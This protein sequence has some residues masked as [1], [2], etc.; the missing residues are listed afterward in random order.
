MPEI[1]GFKA[2]WKRM[3]QVFEK[4]ATAAVLYEPVEVGGELLLQATVNGFDGDVSYQWEFSPDGEEFNDI[5]GATGDTYSKAAQ[6]S[7]AGAYYRFTASDGVKV[8][9]ADAVRIEFEEGE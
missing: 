8:A 4:A 5:A 7:D 1:I 9:T 6:A 2:V 3:V